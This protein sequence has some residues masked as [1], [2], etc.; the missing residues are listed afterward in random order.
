MNKIEIYTNKSCPY[1]K[2]VKEELT[3]AEIEFENKDTAEHKDNWQKIVNL[4]GMP[5]VPTIIRKSKDYVHM[6]HEENNRPVIKTFEV[7]SIYVP[8]R[9]YS[10]PDHLINIL[11]NKE[12]SKHD[13]SRQT[14]EKVKT[15]N[16]NMGQAFQKMDQLLK[17]IETKLNIEENDG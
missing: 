15:L 13:Y 11:N 7:E 5:N 6:D 14:F 10:S 16:Y 1:C 9:D 4:T 3:K 2:S 17:Q 12:G 8:G